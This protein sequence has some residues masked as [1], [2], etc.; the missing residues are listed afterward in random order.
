MDSH[1]HDLKLVRTGDR[2][3]WSFGLELD[4]FLIFMCDVCGLTYYLYR[5]AY[6]RLVSD[7]WRYG[8]V[9]VPPPGSDAALEDQVS[10]Y[11]MVVYIDQQWAKNYELLKDLLASKSGLTHDRTDVRMGLNW[12]LLGSEIEVIATEIRPKLS[13]R[14]DATDILSNG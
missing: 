14:R 5:P 6:Q 3:E 11:R 4:C 7:K 12:R 10:D 2:P 8:E 13:R 9:F 1:K